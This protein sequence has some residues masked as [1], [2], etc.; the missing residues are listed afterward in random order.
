MKRFPFFSQLPRA[1]CH[2]ICGQLWPE[3]K[4][5]ALPYRGRLFLILVLAAFSLT[6]CATSVGVQQND[7][8]ET[9]AQI[10]F[11]A[12]SADDYSRF[13]Q[14]VLTRFDLVQTFNE[15]PQQVL[16]F[17][18]HE[19]EKD[20]RNDLLFALAELNYFVG[21]R[22]RDDGINKSHPHF[23]ASAIYA[24]FY[25]LG[26]EWLERPNPFERR[27]RIACDLYNSALAEAL[28]DAFETRRVGET[29]KVSRKSFSSSWGVSCFAPM[30][31]RSRAVF[32]T[33]R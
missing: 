18:H 20:Y 27:F 11:S 23:F 6:S 1:I 30:R 13:S 4:P 19:A 16:T 25:L 7:P 14:D 21:M 26:K 31:R 5:A 28:A 12:I 15:A 10:S 24:Y 29:W 8:R 22:Y 33:P 9:Y 17:L 2:S 3:K 32:S